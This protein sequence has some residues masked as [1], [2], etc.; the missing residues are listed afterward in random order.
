MLKSLD[1]T[2]HFFLTGYQVYLYLLSGMLSANRVQACFPTRLFSVNSL[3]NV[4]AASILKIPRPFILSYWRVLLM[5]PAPVFGG[6]SCF[7]LYHRDAGGE[8]KL[9]MAF[10]V[11]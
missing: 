8:L 7:T 5:F 11:F 1:F 3:A 6:S 2:H 9:C 4:C 10:E